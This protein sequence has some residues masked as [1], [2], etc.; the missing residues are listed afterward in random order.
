MIFGLF[1]LLV[2]V[3]M[4]VTLVAENPVSGWIFFAVGFCAGGQVSRGTL[5]TRK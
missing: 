1:I 3:S 2:V 4:V 5:T